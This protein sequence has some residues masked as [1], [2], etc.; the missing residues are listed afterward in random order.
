MRAAPFGADTVGQ[1]S[2]LPVS[3]SYGLLP[4]NC[5]LNT[6]PASSAASRSASLLI[7]VKFGELT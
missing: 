6:L 1:I 3:N 5:G 7:G 4:G 2:K